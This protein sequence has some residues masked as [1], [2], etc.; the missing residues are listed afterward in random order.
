MH[1]QD[2]PRPDLVI[3]ATCSASSA[4]ITAVII[5]KTVP[6]K[7][8]KVTLAASVALMA[9]KPA[10]PAHPA[11]NP[12]ITPIK[13]AAPMKATAIA[14]MVAISAVDPAMTIALTATSVTFETQTAAQGHNKVRSQSVSVIDTPL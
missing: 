2:L 11:L 3:S 12:T 9:T 7:R 6:T 14:A 8:L 10:P 5:V 13:A 1:I 4:A